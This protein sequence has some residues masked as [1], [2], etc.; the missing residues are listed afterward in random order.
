MSCV[1]IPVEA[2]IEE[3][4][5]IEDKPPYHRRRLV[6]P[7]CG[8]SIVRYYLKRHN[9]TKKHQDFKYICYEK[10]DMI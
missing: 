2:R 3:P 8:V 5:N 4:E 1:L 6:C 7:Y 9:K 10:F